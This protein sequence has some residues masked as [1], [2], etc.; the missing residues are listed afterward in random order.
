MEFKIMR[1]L[2]RLLPGGVLLLACVALLSTDSDADRLFAQDKKEEMKK[3]GSDEYEIVPIETADK[4]RLSAHWYR[5]PLGKSSDSVMILH[6]YGSSSLDKP[7]W[8][9]LAT[10]LKEKGFSTLVVDLRGHGKSTT[11]RTIG[12]AKI[13]SDSNLFPFNRMAGVKVSVPSSIKGLNYKQFTPGY[14][15]HLINDI[16]AVRFFFD[17]RNDSGECN[18]G[19]I[20]IIAER[21]MGSLALGWITS[22]FKRNGVYPATSVDNPPPLRAGTD[23]VSA[24]FVSMRDNS[25]AKAIWAKNFTDADIFT[26][27]KE[28][29]SML[30]VNAADD[31]TAEGIRMAF[32]QMWKIKSGSKDDPNLNKFSIQVAQ[33]PKLTGVDLLSEKFDA[34]GAVVKFLAST[35][36]KERRVITGN[37]P[38]TRNAGNNSVQVIPLRDYG[39]K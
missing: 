33:A 17:I 2:R 34:A 23:I 7:E 36:D 3:D 37:D 29:I 11:N 32:Y 22:E 24:T 38:R 28:K 6:G 10:Q 1:Y 4:L 35:R 20:H 5:S 21:D 9:A 13:F 31:K 25:S 12:D 26:P 19:R 8:A 39:I 18:S 30:F 27:I 16:A 14:F 15:A